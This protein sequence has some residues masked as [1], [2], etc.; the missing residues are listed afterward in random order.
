MHKWMDRGR[1][2]RRDGWVGGWIDEEWM[3]RGR[4][5]RRVDR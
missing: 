4:V 2:R 1:L 5:R 3:G